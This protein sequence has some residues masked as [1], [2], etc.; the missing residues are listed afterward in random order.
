MSDSTSIPA[1]S[2]SEAVE[3]SE[4]AYEEAAEAAPR[5]PVLHGKAFDPVDPSQFDDPYPWYTA[6]RKDAPV[7]YLPEQ[8]VWC[9]TRYEDVLDVLRDDE[10]FSSRNAVTPRQLTGPLAEVF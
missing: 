9:V 6:A 10:N 7:F 4:L 3:A 2:M 1:A 5:C 8:D